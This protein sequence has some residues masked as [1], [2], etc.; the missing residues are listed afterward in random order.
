MSGILA[1]PIWE[2]P[3]RE[4]PAW[5]GP[6]RRWY[7]I[8]ALVSLEPGRW[9]R[10]AEYSGDNPASRAAWGLRKGEHPIPDGKWEFKRVGSSLYA[11]LEDTH[12]NP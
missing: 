7:E 3:P 11:R 6:R 2:D 8:L 4:H 10:V 5:G 1:E 12:G 9:A